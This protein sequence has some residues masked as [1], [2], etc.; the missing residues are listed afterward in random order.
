[1]NTD[2]KKADGMF[3]NTPP[4]FFIGECGTRALGH[5]H[6]LT[7]GGAYELGRSH[8]LTFIRTYELGHSHL[9]TFGG[10]YEL[11]RSHLLTFISKLM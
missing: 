11:G 8:L 3:L 1:M 6:L 5:S 7:F 9:L 10:A 2:R 4:A